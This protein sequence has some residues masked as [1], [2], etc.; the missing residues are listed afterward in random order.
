MNAQRQSVRRYATTLTV[1]PDSAPIAGAAIARFQFRAISGGVWV[2]AAAAD[3]RRQA[4]ELS[5]CVGR[6]GING[7]VAARDERLERCT[8]HLLCGVAR[9]HSGITG[10]GLRSSRWQRRR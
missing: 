4:V 1:T 5:V 6:W 3:G 2:V 8:Q 9:T 7:V 10:H